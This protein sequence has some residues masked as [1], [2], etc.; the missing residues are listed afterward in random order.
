MAYGSH[1]P[2]IQRYFHVCTQKDCARRGVSLKRYATDVT[3]TMLTGPHLLQALQT[4]VVQKGIEARVRIQETS[5]MRGCWVGPRPNIIG[6][7]GFQ[8][9]VRYLHVPA[10]RHRKDPSGPGIMP[11]GSTDLRVQ[12]RRIGTAHQVM[13]NMRRFAAEVMPAVRGTGVRMVSGRHRKG[14][15]TT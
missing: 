8:E 1:M 4:L 13:T 6:E 10:N 3:A 12:S 15:Q 5:C 9:A 14:G 11:D 7:G 2:A